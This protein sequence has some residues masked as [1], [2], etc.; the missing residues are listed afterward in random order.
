MQYDH[1]C[2]SVVNYSSGHS[3]L[4]PLMFPQR[5][6]IQETAQP[7]AIFHTTAFENERADRGYTLFISSKF[8][9]KAIVISFS[10][11][12]KTLL[13]FERFIYIFALS[14]YVVF[15]RNSST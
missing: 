15:L 1:V 12:S 3:G 9:K 5:I 14:G 2:V 6:V 4:F 10:S 8:D 13:W 7:H 11:L